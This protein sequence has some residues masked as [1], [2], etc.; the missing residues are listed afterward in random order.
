MGKIINQYDGILMD[1]REEIWMAMW[2][3]EAKKAGY[4]KSWKKCTFPMMIFMPVS[5]DYEKVTQL[6]TKVKKEWKKFTLL[7]D[8]EYTPDFIIEWTQKGFLKFVS[9]IGKQILPINPSSWFY[10][11]YDLD[12]PKELHHITHVEVKPIFDRHG[13]TARFGIIQK[14]LWHVKRIFV[15][16]II[17]EDLFKGTFMPQEAMN[18]FKYK[19]LPTGKNKG[20]KKIGD[21]K[22]NYIPKTLNEFQNDVF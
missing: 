5:F 6:K 20:K 14:I 1:S 11:G 10:C 2:M 19:K 9:R 18:D 15:D 22:T 12:N 4:I 17:V 13:K 3:E 8:L 16:L 7:N 21:W